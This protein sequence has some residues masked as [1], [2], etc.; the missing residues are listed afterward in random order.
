MKFS[1]QRILETRGLTILAVILVLLTSLRIFDNS[2]WL[3]ECYSILATDKSYSEIIEYL[4]NSDLHPPLYYFFAKAMADVFGHTPL[5]FHLTSFI[6][7]LLTIIACLTLVR[8]RFGNAAA[9]IVMLCASVLPAAYVFAV[10]VRMYEWG[11]FFTLLC[12]IHA[13]G[14]IN[15]G[16][17][18]GYRDALLLGLYAVL[19]SYT[20]FYCIV[21]AAMIMLALLAAGCLWKREVVRRSLLGLAVFLAGC[22]PMLFMGLSMLGDVPDSFWI[23]SVPDVFQMLGYVFGSREELLLTPVFFFLAI[24]LIALYGEFGRGDLIRRGMLDR[25]EGE[26]RP[27]GDGMFLMVCAFCVFG[28]IIVGYAASIVIRPL[29]TFRY[30]YPATVAAWLMLGMAI[31]KFKVG[32]RLLKIVVCVLIVFFAPAYAYFAVDDYR[33]AVETDETLKA[34]RGISEGD[35]IVTDALKWPEV[36]YY[37]PGTTYDVFMWK[38][39]SPDMLDPGAQNWLILERGMDERMGKRLSD[40]GYGYEPVHEGGSLAKYPVNVYRLVPYRRCGGFRLVYL[41][42]IGSGMRWLFFA[43]SSAGCS[44]EHTGSPCATCS[45]GR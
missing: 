10:E 17:R 26:E 35:H 44:T 40:A 36:Q 39:F 5:V 33:G 21:S 6:P 34:T 20:H 31:F 25:P 4:R 32:M 7:Y 41:R 16:G 42:P 8:E 23:T 24:V 19:A 1:F 14:V 3:D 2:F 29:F 27:T 9:L 22:S 38:S 37:Y 28:T 43:V 18:P 12:L 45:S 11:M 13:H 30:L 15:V